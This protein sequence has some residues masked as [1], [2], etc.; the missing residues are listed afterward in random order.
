[1]LGLSKTSSIVLRWTN[2]SSSSSI[3]LCV[4][5]VILSMNVSLLASSMAKLLSNVNLILLNISMSACTAIC[6]PHLGR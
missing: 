4:L 6:K 2:V 5:V 1:M 3:H